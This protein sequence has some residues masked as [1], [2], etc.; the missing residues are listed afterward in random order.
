[1]FPMM[2]TIVFQMSMFSIL[3]PNALSQITTSL[4]EGQLHWRMRDPEGGDSKQWADSRRRIHQRKDHARRV[5]L[6]RESYFNL[7]S[8]LFLESLW[9][10]IPFWP[11][12]NI[13]QLLALAEDKSGRCQGCSPKGSQEFDE[14]CRVLF[15]RVESSL[16]IAHYVA[17][18]YCCSSPC[19]KV[20]LSC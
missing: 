4:L 8:S 3:L 10:L 13:Y 14:D 17:L 7:S 1:M 16:P 9:E 2:S 6:D 18:L 19:L 15:Y 11:W 12:Y 20:F 5:E